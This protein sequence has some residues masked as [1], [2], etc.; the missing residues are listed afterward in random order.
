MTVDRDWLL[1]WIKTLTLA[2][3][4]GDVCNDLDTLLKKLGVTERWDE[5]YEL[6]DVLTRMGVKYL[7]EE[8]RRNSGTPG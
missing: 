2:D 1:S 4:I 5:L 7:H 3:H 6:S 8:E